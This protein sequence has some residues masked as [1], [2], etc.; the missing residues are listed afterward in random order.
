[1][2]RQ[3]NTGH[4][5]KRQKQHKETKTKTRQRQDKGK[6]RIKARDDMTRQDK[7]RQ[8]EKPFL[9][10]FGVRVGSWNHS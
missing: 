5:N 2:T 9:P 7:A 8:D 4:D 10:S 6:D 1:M 3:H